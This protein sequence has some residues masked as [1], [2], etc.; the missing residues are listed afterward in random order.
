VDLTNEL[1]TTASKGFEL[2]G[3]SVVYGVSTTALTATPTDSLGVKTFANNTP[4]SVSAIAAAG[5][6]FQTAVQSNPYVINQ[7]VSSP[8]FLNSTLSAVTLEVSFPTDTT[9]V[10]DFYGV[11]LQFTRQ[12]L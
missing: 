6:S 2:I 9:T 5:D 12:T 11:G 1:R 3:Y 8:S 10:L 7:T 4:V